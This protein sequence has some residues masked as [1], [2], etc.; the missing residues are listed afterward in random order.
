MKQSSANICFVKITAISHTKGKKMQHPV[1]SFWK[2]RLNDL[3]KVKNRIK[4]VL[5]N[6]N[7]GL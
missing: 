2:I 1:E 6:Q 4:V 7:L 5:I 3:K